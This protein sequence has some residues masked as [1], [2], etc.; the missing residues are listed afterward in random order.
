[1]PAPLPITAQAALDAPLVSPDRVTVNVYAV[2]PLFPSSWSADNATIERLVSSFRTVAVAD[3][4]PSIV[5]V[6]GFDSVTVNPSSGSTVVSP[7]TFTVTVLLVSPA[8]KLTVP[9]G[10]LPPVKSEA[11]AAFVPLPVT[12]HA[13]L[14]APLVSPDRVTVN[15]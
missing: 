3:A 6:L 10:R 14:D 15:V 8:A 12:A 4:V 11:D 2:V 9:L 7:A 13:A 5:P 1:M